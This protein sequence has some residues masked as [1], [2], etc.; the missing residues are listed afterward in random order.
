MEVRRKGRLVQ[1]GAP[2]LL[3]QMNLPEYT[4]IRARIFARLH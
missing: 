4:E 3:T 1:S 2:N